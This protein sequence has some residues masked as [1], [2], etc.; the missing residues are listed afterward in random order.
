MK[1]H[2]WQCAVA[3]TMILLIGVLSAV[4][5]FF[6]ATPVSAVV[7]GDT[8]VI[9]NDGPVIRDAE[10]SVKLGDVVYQLPIRDYPRGRTLIPISDFAPEATA[11]QFKS[12]TVDGRRFGASWVWVQA[13][14][15]E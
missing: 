6:L 1:R 15:D 4:L 13:G 12:S 3:A 8:L 14:V 9:R 2:E 11:E 10:V 5:A 7:E